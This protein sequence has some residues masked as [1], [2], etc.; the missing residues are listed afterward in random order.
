M[1]PQ[2]LPSGSSQPDN[3]ADLRRRYAGKCRI[4][5]NQETKAWEAIWYPTPSTMCLSYA[6]DLATLAVKP[7]AEGWATI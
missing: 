4:A 5:L 2:P 6:P 1:T 3:L 7:N